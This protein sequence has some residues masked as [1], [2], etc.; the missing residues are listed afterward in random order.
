[1]AKE[2]TCPVMGTNVDPE[3]AKKMG[4][5]SM[6]KGKAYYFC[7]PSCK[8]AFDANPEKYVQVKE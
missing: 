2:E 5:S 8:P 1:M 3:K 6:H 7:C 4:W